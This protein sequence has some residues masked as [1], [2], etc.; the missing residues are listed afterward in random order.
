MKEKDKI[1]I[2]IA[3]DHQIVRMGLN[4]IFRKEKDMAVVGEARNGVEAV[5][6]AR[7]LKPDVVLIDLMMPKKNGTAATG[8]IIAENPE[9][10]LLVLTTFS[11]SDDVL[12]ALDA[13][14][15]GALVKDTP[16]EKLIAAIRDVVAGRRVVS[17]E[18]E[19]SIASRAEAQMLTKRQLEVLNYVAKGLSTKDVARIL[20]ITADGVSAHLRTVFAKLGASTR[21]EAVSIA[22]RDR[23]I[24][25]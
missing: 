14:A 22:V 19:N 21:A 6:L 25:V 18:I 4:A 13:G 3:D 11:E 10:K 1:R 23:L 16:Y 7:E 8:E 20:N 24:N 2:L 15:A 5:Q 17:P 9:V 12:A